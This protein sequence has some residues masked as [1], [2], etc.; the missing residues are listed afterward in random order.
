MK[1]FKSILLFSIVFIGCT[2]KIVFEPEPPIVKVFNTDL[3]ISEFS[4]AINTDPNASGTRSHYVELFNGTSSAIDLSNYAVGYF[5]CT[6]TFTLTNFSFTAATTIT[7][8]RILDS[9]KCYVI[10]SP[11]VD[12]TK[13]NRDTTWGTTSTTSANASM[14]LQLSGNSA[15]ALLK[16]DAT[17]TITVAGS[18]YR[19][20]DVFGSPLIRRFNFIGTPS[21]RNNI[22]WQVG[23]ERVDTR[24]RTFF[25]KPTVTTPTTDW[26]LS[27][28]TNNSNSQWILT[29]DRAWDYTNVKMP[30]R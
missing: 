7:L 27:R 24:N 29:S 20:I 17:G 8:N 22:M 18:T 9:S 6:D 28:G 5:A 30:T 26:E 25:R 14:P 11:Q 4:T 10:A 15:I 16:K 12:A 2:S 3:L 19:I 1:F 23:D 13:I 21:A